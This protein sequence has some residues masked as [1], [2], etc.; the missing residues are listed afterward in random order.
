MLPLRC[1]GCKGQRGANKRQRLIYDTPYEPSLAWWQVNQ[2]EYR[3]PPAEEDPL[4][5]E[6]PERVVSPALWDGKILINER[7]RPPPAPP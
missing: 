2:A 1:F 6:F 3:Q 7:K 4:P 5:K